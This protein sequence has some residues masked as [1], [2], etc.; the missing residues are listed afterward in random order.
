MDQRV[1]DTIWDLCRIALVQA[2]VAWTVGDLLPC[3]DLLHEWIHD[4]PPRH[5]HRALYDRDIHLVRMKIGFL[6]TDIRITL[7]CRDKSR[8][9]LYGVH[10][11]GKRA[12]RLDR[13][14]V[15]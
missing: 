14:S 1:R 10:S 5:P 4:R 12:R 13:K 15:V 9:N 2:S 8:G 3:H 11:E 7:F 6:V